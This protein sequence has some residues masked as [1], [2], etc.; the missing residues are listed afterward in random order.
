[1]S[2][3]PTRDPRAE[4]TIVESDMNEQLMSPTVF[5]TAHAFEEPWHDTEATVHRPLPITAVVALAVGGIA[6]IY[7]ALAVLTTVTAEIRVVM[8]VAGL[9]LLYLAYRGIGQRIYGPG[10]QAGLW[11]AVAWLTLTL[12]AAVFA[13]FLPLAEARNPSRT[14]QEPVLAPPDLFSRHPLGTDRQGLDTLGG[15]IYGLRVSAIVGIGAVTIGIIIGGTIGTIAGYFRKAVDQVV[16]LLTNSMLAF[17]PLIL[18]LGIAAVLDRNVRN[19]TITLSVLSIPI[20]A[21]L[22]RAT[23]M[24]IS[25]RDFVLAAK[26]LGA[27]SR[28]IIIKDIVPGVI[29]PVLAYAFV[30]IAA[31][32]VAEASLS[33]LGLGI[34]R[35]EP[36]LG[37]MISAGQGDF[38]TYPHVVFAP[39][40]A[41][42]I[43]VLSLNQ[44]GEYMQSRWN[45]TESKL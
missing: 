21:R 1:M 43:T 24:V 41:L 5:A 35:P 19:T 8:T 9:G 16:E 40:I 23:A 32:V 45:P 12:L 31:I 2:D 27:K 22:A 29:R 20:Y 10:F 33:F 30:I 42:L 14:L 7:V 18:L 15:I 28:R 26:A 36:T 39:A 3:D 11:L 17:P 38:D 4:S 44:I 34:P 37:N 13:D 25:Q 6:A